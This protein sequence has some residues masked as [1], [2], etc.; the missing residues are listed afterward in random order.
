MKAA[1][2]LFLIVVALVMVFAVTNREA[3]G[4]N[5]WPLPWALEVPLFVTWIVAFAAG[6][7]AG[8]LV[9]IAPLWRWRRLAK[10]RKRELARLDAARAEFRVDTPAGEPA[11]TDDDGRL[12]S[13]PHR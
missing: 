3:V 2:W 6:F 5:L 9:M 13:I 1:S 4:V 11:T 7:L 10:Q 12:I 8:G